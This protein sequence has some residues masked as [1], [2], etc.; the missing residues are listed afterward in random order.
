MSAPG[1]EL[2]VDLS[3]DPQVLDFASAVF[4]GTNADSS[5]KISARQKG[6]E[7]DDVEVVIND[8]TTEV[9]V[10]DAQTKTLTLNVDLTGGAT[11][12]QD[13]INLVNNNENVSQYFRA[14]TWGLADGLPPSAI[15][16]STPL[17]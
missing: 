17:R 10:W 12:L 14:E 11:T 5:F 7:F 4:Q 1:Q 8:S 9:A 2:G 6:A 3:S 16:T 13:V 15:P